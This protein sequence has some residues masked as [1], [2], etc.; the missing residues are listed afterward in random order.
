VGRTVEEG[1]GTSLR[2]GV[3]SMLLE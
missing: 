2:V 1:Y 3:W